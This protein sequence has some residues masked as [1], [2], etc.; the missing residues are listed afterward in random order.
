[1]GKMKTVFGAALLG[2]ALA[3]CQTAPDT[4]PASAFAAEPEPPPV[5]LPAPPDP[6]EPR[7][8]EWGGEVPQNQPAGDVDEGGLGD[9]R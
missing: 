8:N 4:E 9:I 5:D 3:A 2:M 6:D 7:L 1:M